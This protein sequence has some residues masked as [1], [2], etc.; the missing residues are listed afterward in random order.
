M[1]L[2]RVRYPHM[3]KRRAKVKSGIERALKRVWPRHRAWV[4]SHH[5]AVPGCEALEIEFAHIRSAATA[6]TGLKPH[7]RYG[8]P[9]CHNHHAEQH[10]VGKGTFE[11]RHG[12][13]LDAIA[14]ELVR[15][16]PDYKLRLSVMLEDSLAATSPE[17]PI[18]HNRMLGGRA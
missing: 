8:V 6:G 1:T 2:V 9:L 4:R 17:I 15:T 5:C 14:A 16:S 3:P 12:I 11:D 13:D 7:D 18:R 10:Q